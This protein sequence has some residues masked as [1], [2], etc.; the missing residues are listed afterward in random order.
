MLGKAMRCPSWDVPPG[1]YRL[2]A[3]QGREAALCDE[4]PHC[5][6]RL[7]PEHAAGC[8]RVQERAVKVALYDEPAVVVVGVIRKA[9][10]P[11]AGGLHRV[12]AIGNCLPS[13]RRVFPRTCQVVPETWQVGVTGSRGGLPGL[14]SVPTPR[15]APRTA[16]LLK[17]HLGACGSD[18]SSLLAELGLRVREEDLGAGHGGHQAMLLPHP[19]GGFLI[20]VDPA[21]TTAE[22]AVGADPV[23]VREFRLWHEFAHSLFYA[24]GMPPQRVLPVAAHEEAFCDAFAEALVRAL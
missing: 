13:T 15:D 7:Q 16:A 18:A 2:I 4:V 17:G 22:A 8:T 19:D 11:L 23:R 10:T 6:L 20:L 21:L 1:M 14:A 5:L 12:Q 3:A 24:P 9:G